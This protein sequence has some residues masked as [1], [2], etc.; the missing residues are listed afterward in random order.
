[1]QAN[2]QLPSFMW[3]NW[4]NESAAGGTGQGGVQ[5]KS[6][7]DTIAPEDLNMLD[8]DFDWQDW[9]QT[10]KGVDMWQGEAP[11]AR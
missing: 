9:T 10:L 11:G 3:G 2:D 1:M 8:Q 7:D 6:M 5:D 4:F